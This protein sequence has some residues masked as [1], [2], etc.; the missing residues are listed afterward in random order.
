MVEDF[1]EGD[2]DQEHYSALKKDF[3]VYDDKWDDALCI[4]CGE[5]Q[6]TGMNKYIL[7]GWASS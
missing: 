1:N 2:E 4:D 7:C 6:G 5:Y 3:G